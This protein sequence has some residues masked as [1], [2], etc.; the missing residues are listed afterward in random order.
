MG[1]FEGGGQAV[2]VGDGDVGLPADPADGLRHGRHRPRRPLSGTT[3]SQ[4][5]LSCF[6]LFVDRFSEIFQVFC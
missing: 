5:L 4:R 3:P 1:T 2:P 6:L